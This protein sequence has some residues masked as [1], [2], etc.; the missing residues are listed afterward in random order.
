MAI[1]PDSFAV[2]AYAP[3]S[4]NPVPLEQDGQHTAYDWTTARYHTAVQAQPDRTRLVRFTH[5]PAGDTVF[6][7][8][9]Q[10][11]IHSVYL[12]ADADG[13]TCFMTAGMSGCKLFIDT[14]QGTNDRVVYHA[15]SIGVG[16]GGAAN[17]EDPLLTAA[18]NTLHDTAK[19][20]WEDEQGLD[21]VDGPNFGR[22]AYN[23]P[24]VAEEGRKRGQ[25]RTR[26]AFMGGT[27]VVGRLEGD[28]WHFYWQTFG[29]CMYRR[30]LSAPKGWF[31]NRDRHINDLR[32]R[33]LGLGEIH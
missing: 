5:D 20:Y 16:G 1:D 8:Y 6:L 24:A 11:E 3:G 10:G 15:N 27:T 17:V 30:P 18:L 4:P 9:G 12:P 19:A 28:D 23:N 25:D 2:I 13:L 29:S 21:L 31:G 32:H 33:V 26:V 14:V 7:P 22:T